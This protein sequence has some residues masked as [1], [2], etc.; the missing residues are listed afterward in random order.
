MFKIFRGATVIVLATIAACGIIAPTTA[1]HAQKYQNTLL[2]F[3]QLDKGSKSSPFVQTQLRAHPLR[4]DCSW[5]DID[6]QKLSN[7]E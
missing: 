2:T 4:S 7:L 3:T 6:V 5:L 1:L